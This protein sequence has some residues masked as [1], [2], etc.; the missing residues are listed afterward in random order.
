MDLS[1]GLF[2][3]ANEMRLSSMRDTYLAALLDAWE[4][5]FQT[6]LTTQCLPVGQLAGVGAKLFVEVVDQLLGLL[7]PGELGR[8]RAGGPLGGPIRG[9]G[10]MVG[11]KVS[12][13]DASSV[14]NLT[15]ERVS[16]C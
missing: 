13:H 15:D 9:P 16:G 7:L 11:W 1:E 4:V 6:N 14:L 8:L 5:V 2:K 12:P 10:N 3:L